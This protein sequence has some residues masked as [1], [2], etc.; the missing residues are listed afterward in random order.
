MRRRLL[1]AVALVATVSVQ[2]LGIA[3]ASSQAPSTGVLTTLFT[4]APLAGL[5]TG[6]AG[7]H[8]VDATF[9]ARAG[10]R[11]T[12]STPLVGASATTAFVAVTPH[13]TTN[14]APWNRAAGTTPTTGERSA[15]ISATTCVT[16]GA[17]GVTTVAT[18][19]VNGVT[20]S[21]DTDVAL[22]TP[23]GYV[24]TSPVTWTGLACSSLSN[25][26]ATGT[27]N[28]SGVG[29]RPVEATLV[30]G[31][32]SLN[33]VEPT[34]VAGATGP[35]APSTFDT[36]TAPASLNSPICPTATSCVAV[37]SYQPGDGTTDA[38]ALTDVAGTL[39]ATATVPF[40][41]ARSSALTAVRCSPHS[42][43][44]AVGTYEAADATWHAF[45][46]A[47]R[48]GSWTSAGLPGLPSGSTSELAAL[49]C[50]SAT[51]CW[52]AGDVQE[53]GL[54]PSALMSAWNGSSWTTPWVLN[55]NGAAQ[56]HL[57]GIACP[58]T[59]S[60][61]AVGDTANVRQV[62]Q[63]LL[64]TLSN[65]QWA[66]R[67]VTVPA[68]LHLPTVSVALDEVDCTS[69][70]YCVGGGVAGSGA[71]TSAVALPVNLLHASLASAPRSLT[72]AQRSPTALELGWSG[73]ARLGSTPLLGFQYTVNGGRTWMNASASTRFVIVTHLTA[74]TTYRVRVR[75]WN[76]LGA[77]PVSTLVISRG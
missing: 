45:Y 68:A 46:A 18:T 22:R 36:D 58:T 40:P 25:C 5:D 56:A 30:Q 75:T 42:S 60:C 11:I 14:P 57:T 12:S 26:L 1:T 39:N 76:A 15:C 59:T 29:A 70:G 51:T 13:W 38:F 64:A 21:S 48:Q 35:V 20:V 69:S 32:W 43:C 53:A 28:Q 52:A 55:V 6:F 24:P 7:V 61:V 44:M 4:S 34:T 49:T 9:T 8:C 23:S 62:T 71:A 31:V 16:I 41:G 67:H 72:V 54:A 74:T 3:G 47:Y 73:P 77:G 10:C 27:V 65:S 37:G 66:L 33:F 19:V 50:P 2:P 63:P 17:S